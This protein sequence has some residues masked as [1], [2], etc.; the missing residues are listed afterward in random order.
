VL[1]RTACI[2]SVNERKDAIRWVLESSEDED[3]SFRWVA[4]ELQLSQPVEPAALQ[5]A[6]VPTVEERLANIEK[7]LLMIAQESGKHSQLFREILSFSANIGINSGYIR[8]MSDEEKAEL[9]KK[10]EAAEKEASQQASTE[11]KE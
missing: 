9:I 7:T 8:M 3:F 6:I 4:K 5:D 11:T 2:T 10:K 1:T